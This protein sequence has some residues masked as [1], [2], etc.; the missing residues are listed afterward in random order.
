MQFS[1]AADYYQH[2]AGGKAKEFMQALT[3]MLSTKLGISTH[4][5]RDLEVKPGSIIVTFTLL[6]NNGNASESS[7]VATKSALQVMVLNG[8]LVLTLTDGTVLVADPSSVRFDAEATPAPKAAP[9][10][11][12]KPLVLIAV[13]TVLLLL[14]VVFLAARFYVVQRRRR[15][16]IESDSRPTSAR[17]LIVDSIKLEDK[18]DV[19][20]SN[21]VNPV[22][23]Y[24]N[25]GQEIC[26][27]N[28]EQM[29]DKKENIY[30]KNQV[31]MVDQK[32][33]IYQKNKETPNG[34]G[35]SF[36]ISIILF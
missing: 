33:N 15:R 32:E 16:K 29:V 1:F 17:S 9:R 28:K 13:I 21:Y 10:P 11:S 2:A 36:F 30:E 3:N 14:L 18:E 23:S 25:K 5:I 12:K 8:R 6:G 4:R 26:E 24:D 20:K 35:G 31:Q 34:R 27:Q 7:L 22:L 19:G